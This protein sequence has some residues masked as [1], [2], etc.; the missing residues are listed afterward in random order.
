MLRFLIIFSLSLFVLLVFVWYLLTQ[1]V[2]LH[3]EKKTNPVRFDADRLRHFVEVIV[4][5]YFPRDAARVHNLNSCA[6]YIR[7]EF[8]AHSPRTDYQVITIDQKEYKNVIAS[9]GPEDGPRIIVGAHY[10]TAGEQPGAD[11]NASGVAALLALAEKL[12]NLPLKHRV[13]LVAYTLEEPPYYRTANMGSARHVSLLKESNV[14]VKLMIALEMLGY[15]SEEPGS[16]DYPVGLLK[17]FYPTTGNYIAI[18]GQLGDGKTVRSAK[19]LMRAA[20]DVPVY[21]INAPRLI[22][23]IDFS[24]HMNFWDEGYP[25]IMIT[26][27]AFYRNRAYHTVADLPQ[28]LDYQKMASVLQGVFNIIT[29]Y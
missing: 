23:G 28:R 7:K 13:D 10:D 2:F 26:D 21:S 12:S 9:F 1:P 3:T 16:Q 5:D 20:S 17:L 29:G 8:S 27:T 4:S 24:D 18:V 19:E 14:D 15:Y 22:P 25:A 11:D 6:R